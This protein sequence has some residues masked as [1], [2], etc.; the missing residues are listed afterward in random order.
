[1]QVVILAGVEHPDSGLVHGHSS[2][3]FEGV[4]RDH[5]TSQR[6]SREDLPRK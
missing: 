6:F 4:T 1:M 3:G 5:E 2:M